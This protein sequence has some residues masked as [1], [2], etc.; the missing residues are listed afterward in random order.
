MCAR[1]AQ[2]HIAPLYGR[3]ETVRGVPLHSAGERGHE[4]R[5]ERR[6]NRRSRVKKGACKGLGFVLAYLALAAGVLPNP[7]LNP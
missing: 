4:G 5:D 6:D 2:P 1:V 3:T 7:E